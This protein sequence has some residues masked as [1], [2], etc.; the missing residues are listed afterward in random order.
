[1][2]NYERYLSETTEGYDK[3]MLMSYFCRIPSNRV[4]FPILS[5]YRG[6]K[7]LEVGLGTG[8]YTKLLCRQDNHV[9]GVDRNP[10]LCRLPIKVYGG[11]ATELSKL[12][13]GE[14][15]DLVISMWMTDYLDSEQLQTFFA[16]SKKVLGEGGKFV[17]TVISNQGLGSMYVTLAKMVRGIDKHCYKKKVVLQMLGRAGFEDINVVSLNSWCFVPWAYLVIAA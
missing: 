9:V 11:D 6:K 1:M 16:E 5:E 4:I 8:Y 17:T 12:T 2:K 10:H 7:I 14:R 13:E 3:K 15:F